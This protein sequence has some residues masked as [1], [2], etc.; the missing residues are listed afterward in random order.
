MPTIF[1]CFVGAVEENRG[2]EEEL[3]VPMVNNNN[4]T[5]GCGSPPV[6]VIVERPSFAVQETVP[7]S[8]EMGNLDECAKRHSPGNEPNH[9]P[10]EEEEDVV[11][12]GRF[13][14]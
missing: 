14:E 9:V 11:L 6:A 4:E 1:P 8:P 7:P 5:A 3:K 13:D 12:K 2:E 10:I